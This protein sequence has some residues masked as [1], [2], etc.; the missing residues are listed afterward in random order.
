M[1]IINFS[2]FA[3]DEI[4]QQVLQ[5]EKIGAVI[6]LWTGKISEVGYDDIDRKIATAKSLGIPIHLHPVQ[7]RYDRKGQ[8]PYKIFWET[9]ELSK[10]IIDRYSSATTRITI[11]NE[12]IVSPDDAWAEVIRLYAWAG[13]HHP[14]LQL[15]IGDYG[16]YDTHRRRQIITKLKELKTIV[17][18]VHGFIGQDYV[19]LDTGSAISRSLKSPALGA[20]PLLKFQYLNEF[21]P[22]IKSL[23]YVFALEHSTFSN[24]DTK[25]RRKTQASIYNCLS[26]L[27]HRTQSEFW[28]WDCCDASAKHVRTSQP[29]FAGVWDVKGNL[30]THG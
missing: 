27:C 24:T 20:N 8:K 10:E 21:I 15:W 16:I 12:L 7:A 22:R 2:K 28:L 18:A 14:H 6:S 4:T 26:R 1:T 30:K 5:R 29:R 13:R 25:A 11:A 23:G 3:K 19:D 17:P 9:L